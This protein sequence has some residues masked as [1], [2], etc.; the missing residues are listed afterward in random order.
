MNA[1]VQA[2]GAALRPLLALLEARPD[3][4]FVEP[5]AFLDDDA[6]FLLPEFFEITAREV[7]WAAAARFSARGA[8]RAARRRLA[9]T[10]PGWRT[11]EPRDQSALS[12]AFLMTRRKTFEELGG[13]DEGYPLYYE[14]SDLFRRARARGMGLALQ[15]AAEIVH[16]AHRSVA[17]VW[18]EAAAKAAAG[19]QRYLRAHCGGFAAW[20]DRTADGLAGRLHRR[21][22][23]P[24]PLGPVRDLGV[25]EGPPELHFSGPGSPHLVELALE[26]RFVLA[27][28]RFE[29]G[30][31]CRLSTR[32]WSSLAPGRYF[33]RAVDLR[34]LDS[35]TG[36]TFAKP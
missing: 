30:P 6:T 26:P 17:T 8:R 22:P 12:G 9:R 23:P 20:L 19:R 1:D 15:P 16:Y 29:S 28:G 11:E 34:T 18:D 14:D 27:A 10:L 5:R 35:R 36:L 25:L 21:R 32:T 2:R 4:A 33:T 13:F 7:W 24:A 3:L 31:S